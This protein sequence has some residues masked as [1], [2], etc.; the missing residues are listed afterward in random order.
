[1]CVNGL[2]RMTG[3]T[4]G[5][6]EHVGAEIARR[7]RAKG[8]SQEHLGELTELAPDTISRIERGDRTPH[9]TTL[10]SIL[11]ALGEGSNERPR[12]AKE[13]GRATRRGEAGG[14]VG[15]EDRLGDLLSYI[16]TLE[17]KRK[18][19]FI[20]AV[21]ALLNALEHARPAAGS[22]SAPDDGR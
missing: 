17:G 10:K 12:S 2:R 3:Y 6:S 5:V 14:G 22:G 15:I 8:W 4:L 1:M 13:A 19:E 9:K 11:E 7:R 16:G 18:S 21:V 20:R